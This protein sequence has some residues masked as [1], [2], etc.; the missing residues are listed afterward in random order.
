MTVLFLGLPPFA[1]ASEHADRFDEALSESPTEVE[2]ESTTTTQGLAPLSGRSAEEWEFMLSIY[3]WMANLEGSNTIGAITVPIGVDFSTIWDNLDG[4]FASHFEFRKGA[5][6]GFVDFSYFAVGKDDIT[7]SIER[8]QPTQLPEDLLP[9]IEFDFSNWIFEA[10]ATYR[11]GSERNAFDVF[12]GLRYNRLAQNVA[13]GGQFNELSGGYDVNWTDPVFGG[14]YLGRVHDRV[15]II[16]RGDVGGFGAGSE[17]TWNFQGGVTIDV[18]RRIGLNV[19]YKYM[20]ID[21][22]EGTRGNRDYFEYEATTQG[23]L[24]GISFYF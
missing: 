19:L 5:W 12:G 22:E 21:Y 4:A 23:A 14:R 9:T 2:L 1:L 10:M 6:G 18:H 7:I 15:W 24:L 3:L 13:I 16:A 20:D 17:L 11:F 8:P